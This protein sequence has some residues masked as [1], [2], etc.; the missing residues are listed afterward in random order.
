MV[1]GRSVLAKMLKPSISFWEII[2]MRMSMA[3]EMG[4]VSA[5]ARF[6]FVNPLGEQA[7]A[8]HA[9][10]EGWGVGTGSAGSR[11]AD[12][13]NVIWKESSFAFISLP[14]SDI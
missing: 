13:Q 5:S 14:A 11:A 1:A 12:A 8:Q 3:H 6:R 2:S 7:Q 9:C 4:P 10:K